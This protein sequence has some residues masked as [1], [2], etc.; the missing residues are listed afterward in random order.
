MSD[1][2]ARKQPGYEPVIS[3]AEGLGRGR[4]AS[5]PVE[6]NPAA[7]RD[8]LLQRGDLLHPPGLVAYHHS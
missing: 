2:K 8:G 7:P 5:T 4:A 6:P 1:S 3:R